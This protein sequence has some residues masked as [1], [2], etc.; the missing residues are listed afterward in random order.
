[1]GV[2]RNI[3]IDQARCS[4]GNKI[5]SFCKNINIYIVTAPPN[6][7]RAIELLERLIQTVKRRLS[8]MKLVKRTNK[9]TIKEAI[10]S[11]VSITYMQSKD[12]KCKTIPSTFWEESKH[13]T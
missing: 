10:K 5:E 1:M 4:I 8:C 2:P 11:S 13:A 7:H 12:S 6:D 3:R 9:T